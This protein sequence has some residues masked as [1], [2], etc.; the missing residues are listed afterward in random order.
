MSQKDLKSIEVED[1]MV[2]VEEMPIQ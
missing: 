1:V 2:L